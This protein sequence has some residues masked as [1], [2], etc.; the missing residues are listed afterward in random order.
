M[1]AVWC[2]A[3]EHGGDR[4]ILHTRGLRPI[5]FVPTSPLFPNVEVPCPGGIFFV[6][7]SLRQVV[8]LAA[9]AQKIRW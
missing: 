9:V 6:L 8:P 5:A 3:R 2:G 7:G 1:C 4:F